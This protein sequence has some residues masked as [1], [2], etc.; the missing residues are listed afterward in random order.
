M[1]RGI[2]LSIRGAAIEALPAKTDAE[3]R[4]RRTSRH[5]PEPA[6]FACEGKAVFAW[7]PC[8]SASA[9][10]TADLDSLRLVFGDRGHPVETIAADVKKPAP[11]SNHASRASACASPVFGVR[12]GKDRPIRASRLAPS[13]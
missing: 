13:A 8:Q 12:A 11:S 7:L 10:I 1:G 6:T 2:G 4:L 9:A 5:K 3:A